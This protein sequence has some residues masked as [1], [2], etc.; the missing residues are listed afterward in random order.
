MDASVERLRDLSLTEIINAEVSSVS[1]RDERL[2]ES[3]TAVFVITGE[4]I[5][6]S[7][8]LTIAEALRLAPGISVAQADANTWAVASR[9]FNDVFT[10]KLLVMVDGRSVYSNVTGALWW[11]DVSYVMEDIERIEVIRGP[12]GTIWGANAVN[13]VINIIT[14]SAR[15]TQGLLIIGGGGSDLVG[16]GKVRYGDRLAPD[17]YGRVYVQHQ[18]FGAHPGGND[19]WAITQT[20]LRLDYEPGEYRVTFQGDYYYNDLNDRITIPQPSPSYLPVYDT[21]GVSEGWN[22]LG[23]IEREI[24]EDSALR[25]QVYYDA[26]RQTRDVIDSIEKAQKLD[27]DFQ[28]YFV[29]PLGQQLTYGLEYRYLPT[30]QN[31]MALWSWSRNERDSQLVTGFVQDQVELVEDRLR[32]TI[33]S[34]F[35]HNDFTGWEAQPDARLAW[36]FTDRQAVWLAGSRSVSIP[37]IAYN[38]IQIPQLA[39]EP[40]FV[41]AGPLGE[42]PAFPGVYGNP[43]LDAQ[44]VFGLE[45]GWRFQPQDTLSLDVAAFYNWYENL[46]YTR[47]QSPRLEL[48]PSPWI[49][50]PTIIANNAS[51]ETTGVEL[52][53]AWRPTEWLRLAGYYAFLHKNVFNDDTGQ[54]LLDQEKD[55]A[56]QASLRLSFDLPANVT[57]DLWG[58]FVDEI[59]YY[60]VDAYVD[61]DVRVAWRLKTTVEIAVVGQNLLDPQRW[62]FGSG[63]VAQYQATPVPRGV[64]GQLT[65]RF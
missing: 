13:G 55:V 59:P 36:M 52:S 24:S 43:D 48:T 37:S 2:F 25:L 32:L 28:H 44:E 42:L 54:V 33:G 1:K 61:L 65:L 39:V 17:L 51:S 30:Y 19:Q 34:K 8:A 15:D 11:A 20:G 41:D 6:R 12:G 26:H 22:V 57:L 31:D 7:G 56:H 60:A 27:V 5:Q 58:R 21:S 9:G 35:E 10:D 18:S 50:V 64:Y 14:K 49:Q 16:Q 62:E 63:T 23:R 40:T 47:P 46:V 3:P 53:A 29:L 38:D 4:D 45:A